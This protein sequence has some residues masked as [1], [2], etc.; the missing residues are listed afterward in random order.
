LFPHTVCTRLA[1]TGCRY[2]GLA[3][4][5]DEGMAD[6]P[7][8]PAGGI[9]AMKVWPPPHDRRDLWLPTGTS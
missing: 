2:F 7:F 1:G 5:S 4:R 9:R 3:R 6:G 8:R